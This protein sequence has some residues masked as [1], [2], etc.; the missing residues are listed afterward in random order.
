MKE[1]LIEFLRYLKIGQLAFEENVGL[2]RGF[3]N[4]IGFSIRENSLKKISNKYPKLNITWLLTGEGNM[5]KNTQQTGVSI[6]GMNNNL[7]QGKNISFYQEISPETIENASKNYR[8]IIQEQQE[9]IRKLQ[10]QLDKQRETLQ[11][12]IDRLLN[13]LEKQK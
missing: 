8:Q 12:T 4:N 13:L 2:S 5:L 10:Q 9:T 1:R 6:S 3:V 7:Q 11:G